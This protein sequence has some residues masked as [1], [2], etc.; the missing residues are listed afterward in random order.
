VRSSTTELQDRRRKGDGERNET[1]ERWK[2][3]A[4]EAES[5][6]ATE[7]LALLMLEAGE[8]G[9]EKERGRR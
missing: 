3:S 8:E 7:F 9:E 5:G 6:G 1:E 2:Q 4:K